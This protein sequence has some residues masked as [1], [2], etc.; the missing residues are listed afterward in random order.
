MLMVKPDE[1]ML[2]GERTLKVRLRES[3]LKFPS[4]DLSLNV[5]R[6]A[7]YSQGFLNRQLIVLLSC[8]GVPD[9]VFL[10]LQ[11][12]AKELASVTEIYKKLLHRTSKVIRSFR[13]RTSNKKK[14]G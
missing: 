10:D 9:N 8:L 12:E 13:K 14:I 2:M 6:C 4:E 5:V 3:Q 11:R 1:D 7:T